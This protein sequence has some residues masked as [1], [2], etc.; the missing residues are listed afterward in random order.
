MLRA[1]VVWTRA[2][3]GGPQ[4]TW[5]ASHFPK[6]TAAFVDPALQRS[7]TASAKERKVFQLDKE[8]T[9]PEGQQGA[10]YDKGY[11]FKKGAERLA[12]WAESARLTSPTATWLAIFPALWGC[13]LAVTRVLVWEGADPIVLTTPMLPLHLTAFFVVG[14]FM[15][16]GA[17]G[18]IQDFLMYRWPSTDPT[19]K[20]EEAPLLEKIRAVSPAERGGMLGAH[21]FFCGLITLNL[22]P[23]AAL[24][25]L[26]V[27]P[28]YAL[29][30]FLEE[31]RRR[32]ICTRPPLPSGA[33]T[34]SSGNS[35][36][37]PPE[38][39]APSQAALPQVRDRVID[40]LR[41]TTTNAGVF[42]GYAAV[43]GRLDWSIVGPLYVACCGW[44]VVY[45]YIE[46]L[47]TSARTRLERLQKQQTSRMLREKA[48]TRSVPGK[49]GNGS[50]SSTTSNALSTTSAT[51]SSPPAR[52][53]DPILASLTGVAPQVP[54]GEEDPNYVHPTF[55]SELQAEASTAAHSL[56]DDPKFYL[57]VMLLPV[58]FG[59][60]FAGVFSS[61]AL[62]YYIGLVFG[63]LYLQGMID[64]VNMYDAWS[65]QVNYK[66]NVRFGLIVLG[67]ILAGNAFWGLATEHVATKD[68]SDSTEK[69]SALLQAMSLTIQP[70][71]RP[72]DVTEFNW[73]DRFTRPVWVQAR[74][75]GKRQEE[76]GGQ[77]SAM[78]GESLVKVPAWMR[79]EYIG[80]NLRSIVAWTG[81]VAAE[82]LSEWEM[83][84][85]SVLDHYNVFT[86]FT[87]F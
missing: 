86:R 42:I 34:S 67:S 87:T 51:N 82:T 41:V 5:S 83:W 66:R 23:V 49:L 43:T 75:L 20:Q 39:N 74:V 71:A 47:Q 72:Y 13:G 28:L 80:Q 52:R 11:S 62:L 63:I 44:T 59:F 24:S 84:W 73:M 21:L 30:L 36:P 60:V 58:T 53:V 18:H 6:Q 79:R 68:K 14:G 61:Q 40:V 48:P 69:G 2:A 38:T 54:V 65:C 29:R 46:R 22:A 50:S 37:S 70:Y 55:T 15:A 1:S 17:A 7:G 85:Y 57:N 27:I 77:Q 3:R 31:W 25:V 10:T 64:H 81:L 12:R 35:Q 33:T 9:L 78:D 4:R 45:E 19:T 32:S 56:I 16:R 76:A 26:A 8:A